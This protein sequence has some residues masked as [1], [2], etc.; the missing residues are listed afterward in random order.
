CHMFLNGGIYGGK[1][2]L[3]EAR[4]REATKAQTKHTHPEA[5]RDDPRQAFYG[6]GWRVTDGVHAHGG[7]DGTYGWVDP[8]RQVIGLVFTQSPGGR[9]PRNQFERVVDAACAGAR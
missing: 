8:R 1:R 5:V 4:V 9:N 6:F 3:S 2:L 7:S